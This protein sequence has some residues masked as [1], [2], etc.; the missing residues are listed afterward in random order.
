VSTAPREKPVDAAK[1]SKNKKKKLK[2]KAKKQ[3][4]LMDLQMQQITEVEQEKVKL[5]CYCS[6]N[7]PVLSGTSTF[8]S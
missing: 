7:N 6:P 4:Q 8:T 3:Q 1:M 5:D 2:K